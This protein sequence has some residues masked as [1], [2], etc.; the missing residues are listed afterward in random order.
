[1]E[2]QEDQNDVVSHGFLA[3]SNVL[4]IQNNRSRVKK[5]AVLIHRWG[6][7]QSL[8]VGVGTEL[9]LRANESELYSSTTMANQWANM[10][11]CQYLNL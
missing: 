6:K 7:V 1:M 3:L 4:L 10:L 8:H 2:D 5:S 9:V 11:G